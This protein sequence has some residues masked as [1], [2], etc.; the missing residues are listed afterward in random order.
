ME[1]SLV[2]MDDLGVP[3]D[4]GKPHCHLLS[5]YVKLFHVNMWGKCGETC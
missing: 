5:S 2:K 1:N 4:L 3:H